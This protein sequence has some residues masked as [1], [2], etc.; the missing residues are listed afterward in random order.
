MRPGDFSSHTKRRTYRPPFPPILSIRP[1]YFRS[2]GWQATHM[3]AATPRTSAMIQKISSAVVTIFILL[4]INIVG[5][6][7]H[8]FIGQ[9]LGSLKGVLYVTTEDHIDLQGLLVFNDVFVHIHSPFISGGFRSCSSE[10]DFYR[11]T[12]GLARVQTL[13]ISHFRILELS[14]LILTFV[15]PV[16]LSLSVQE[17]W[18]RNSSNSV[19][20]IS[21]Q[22]S[23]SANPKM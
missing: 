2:S 22:Q 8:P 16:L 18:V 4:S 12:L 15:L 19:L 7:D 5:G 1:S 6:Q 10:P 13:A 11:L 14:L 17:N 23:A 21:K 20:L 3:P 9:E